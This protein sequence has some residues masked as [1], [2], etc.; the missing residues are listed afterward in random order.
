MAIVAS[1]SALGAVIHPIMLNNTIRTDLGF[2]NAVRASAGLV[3]GLLVIACLLMHPRVPTSPTYPPVW[4]SLRRFTRDGAYIFATVG[5][6]VAIAPEVFTH[7][8][9][10]DN[11]HNGFLLPDILPP[12]RRRQTRNQ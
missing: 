8:W 9:Q 5:Y 6:A 3:S 7:H 2:G 1:G 10:N 11:I 4:K 12:A